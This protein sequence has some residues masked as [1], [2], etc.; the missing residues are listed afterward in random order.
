[1]RKVNIVWMIG[2]VVAGLSL[3]QLKYTVRD[4]RADADHMQSELLKEQESLHVL[5]AEWAHLS[6]PERLQTLADKYLILVPVSGQQ[7][8]TNATIKAKLEPLNAEDEDSPVQE[9][10]YGR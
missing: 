6:S 3:Y 2:L 10:G 4:I 8:A 5:R 7:L 1:M 9:A